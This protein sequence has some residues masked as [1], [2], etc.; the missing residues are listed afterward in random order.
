M[1]NKMLYILF[2][3]QCECKEN[4]IGKNCD[5]CKPLHYD[6]DRGCVSCNCFIQGT[7]DGVGE[8]DREVSNQY[9]IHWFVV[10]I[11]IDSMFLQSTILYLLLFFYFQDGQCWCRPYTC[12]QRCS[13]C[14]DGF[15]SLEERNY[16][17]CTSCECDIG[18]AMTTQCDKTNGQCRCKNG[19]GGRRCNRYRANILSDIIFCH[20]VLVSFG[21]MQMIAFNA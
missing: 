4:V 10:P 20:I 21:N 8:C 9:F 19:I 16:L 5:M 13:Q 18:G 1:T 2:Q 11:F 15:Y 12:T 17:G 6:I 3:G 7:L 14:E